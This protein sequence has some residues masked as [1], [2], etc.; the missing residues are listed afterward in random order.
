MR[1]DA[2]RMPNV[3]PRPRIPPSDASSRYRAW[4][5]ERGTDERDQSGVLRAESGSQGALVV[6]SVNIV[7]YP[8]LAKCVL[9]AV[10]WE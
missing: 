8:F 1:K 9:H 2:Q 10:C 3:S 5:D 6:W 4:R 7:V